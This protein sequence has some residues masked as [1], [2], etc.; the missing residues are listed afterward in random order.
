MK[1]MFYV[2]LGGG[3]GSI[4]R[5]LISIAVQGK[6]AMPWATILANV[7]ASLILGMLV[8]WMQNAGTLDEKWRLMW[9]VGF[10]GGFSTF[11]TFSYESF[12]LLQNQQWTALFFNILISVVVCVVCIFLGMKL[13]TSI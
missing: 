10:C 5:Y 13:I 1:L 6:G 2:F 3:L 11:S 8:G 4:C 9:M 12:I 7:I